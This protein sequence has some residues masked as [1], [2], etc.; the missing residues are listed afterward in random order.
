MNK[1][2]SLDLA[3]S[4]MS[5]KIFIAGSF[6]L[7]FLLYIY[8]AG[9]TLS[10]QNQFYLS[11]SILIFLFL[12]KWTQ[13]I[14]GDFSR[15]ALV[16]LSAYLSMRYW[17]FSNHFNAHLYRI[18]RFYFFNTSLCGRIVWHIH[19]PYGNVGEYISFATQT[20]AFTRRSTSTTNG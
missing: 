10:L 1:A 15:I 5:L 20:R 17:F 8:S 13:P 9:L 4:R 11:L 16:T 3:V 18:F 2:N 6:L 14:L 19:P 12:F 7:L